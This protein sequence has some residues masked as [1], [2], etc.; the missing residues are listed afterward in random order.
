MIK[1]G[2]CKYSHLRPSVRYCA[3]EFST[4]C[5]ALYG[6]AAFFGRLQG[7]RRDCAFKCHRNEEMVPTAQWILGRIRTVRRDYMKRCYV[8]D[9]TV[10]RGMFR[11]PI[12]VAKHLE[13]IVNT[14]KSKYKRGTCF[15]C[16][17]TVN[18]IVD[19]SRAFLGSKLFLRGHS[20]SQTIL[21]LVEGCKRKGIKIRS[22]KIDAIK[23][24]G[25]KEAINEFKEGRRDG[26]APFHKVS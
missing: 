20:N 9:R 13:K 24:L 2:A 1:S 15:N 11:T 25:V 10:R 8:M 19:G 17:A 3:F 4:R 12:D 21:K 6:P 26:L 23:T 14:I 16:L 5:N 18:C 7:V 22:L